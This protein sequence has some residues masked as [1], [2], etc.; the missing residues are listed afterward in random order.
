MCHFSNCIDPHPANQKGCK[1]NDRTFTHIENDD[2]SASPL[3]AGASGAPTP[4]PDRNNEQCQPANRQK[5]HTNDSR[6]VPSA[7]DQEDTP[8]EA[9]LQRQGT[10]RYNLRPRPPTSTKLR[11]FVLT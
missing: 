10:G 1:K 4:V 7:D 6:G 5:S 2:N 9:L 8:D 11:D 3:R